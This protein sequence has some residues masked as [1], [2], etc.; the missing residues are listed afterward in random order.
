[1]IKKEH[2]LLLDA[3]YILLYYYIITGNIYV[4]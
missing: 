3:D 4:E 1:M 2:K